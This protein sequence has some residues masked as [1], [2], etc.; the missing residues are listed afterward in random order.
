MRAF[1]P[2]AFVS[3]DDTSD[4]IVRRTI[5]EGCCG[6]EVLFSPDGRRVYVAGSDGLGI[7]DVAQKRRVVTI[8]IPYA[9][10]TADMAISSDGATAYIA[11]QPRFV[12]HRT[13][14]RRVDV[15]DTRAQAVTAVI[16]DVGGSLAV[17]PDGGRLYA[18]EHTRSVDDVEPPRTSVIDTRSLMRIGTIPAGGGAIGIAPNGSVRYLATSEGLAVVETDGNT[19]L[20]TLADVHP[21][22]IAFTPDGRFAYVAEAD[23]VSVIDTGTHTRAA[24]LPAS[25]CLADI[26][27]DPE[28]RVAYAPNPIESAVLTIDV[29]TNTVLPPIASGATRVATGAVPRGCTAARPGDCDGDAAV[30]VAELMTGI[31]IA[32]EATPPARCAAFD[33]DDDR[34]VSIDELYLAVDTALDPLPAY[35]GR[36][37][38]GIAEPARPADP[39]QSRLIVSVRTVDLYPCGGYRLEATV[40]VTNRDIHVDLGAVVPPSGP[41]LTAPSPATAE[42]E[43]NLAYGIYY[44]VFRS[45]LS[46]ADDVSLLRIELD[47]IEIAP[48]SRFF[49]APDE[50]TV[51]RGPT[52]P[53]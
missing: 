6:F 4:A 30:T 10:S 53:P 47:H 14:Y 38:F 22:A 15:I 41:C 42:L 33:Q 26:A 12:P 17:S 23:G 48:Y 51:P 39:L 11:L 19:L 18:T 21:I 28:G 52:P 7:I 45:Q 9:Y 50:T 5:F 27:I 2:G 25:C 36:I 29:P 34:R 44:L 13:I 31:A 32:L 40:N 43:V 16:D 46:A 37:Q 1:L 20:R 49:A 3:V 8:A 24:R 35:A